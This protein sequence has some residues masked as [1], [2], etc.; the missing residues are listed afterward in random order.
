MPRKIIRRRLSLPL[1][2]A[3]FNEAAASMPR[4]MIQSVSASPLRHC[5]SFNEA[6]ASMPRK[7]QGLSR[8]QSAAQSC[9][10]EAAASMPRKIS[11]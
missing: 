3:C 8:D 4:K 1:L 10:N 11:A 7:I 9:F 5:A 2:L 6:A